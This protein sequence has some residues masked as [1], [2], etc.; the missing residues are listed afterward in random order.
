MNINYKKNMKKLKADI[1][2]LCATMQN[3]SESRYETGQYLLAAWIIKMLSKW[4]HFSYEIDV[5]GNLYITKGKAE[6]YPC[7]VAHLDT[8]HSFVPNY[9]I[10][11]VGNF[12]LAIDGDTG[13]Q[14]GTGCDDR[15][16]ITIAL[17]MF[18][19][20]D[21]IKLFFPTNEEIGGIGSSN[22]NIDFFKD[23]CFLI[24]PDRNMY[25]N[26]KDYINHTNGIDVTTAEFDVAISPYIKAHGYEEE[27]GTFTDIGILLE[28]GAGC[29]AFN[30]SCYLNAHTEQEV[31]FIP[32]YED[33]L[34]LVNDV[35]VNMSYKRWEIKVVKQRYDMNWLD[36]YN[37]PFKTPVNT[38]NIYDDEPV[39]NQEEYENEVDAEV[40]ICALYCDGKFLECDI[41]NT[42]F[43]SKCKKTIGQDYLMQTMIF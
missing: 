19:E 42:T 33:A 26:K 29:C 37:L 17:Q 34:N 15:V 20:H 1:G 18:Q 32:L 27:R 35:I 6:L 7:I 13:E 41:D 5:E 43:C 11:R 25:A 16:G 9:I 24:Q 10:T 30:L 40:D 36:K 4:G 28:K 12:I 21:N 2:L 23:C 22:C 14:V 8:V 38:L 31:C 39:F 3:Q